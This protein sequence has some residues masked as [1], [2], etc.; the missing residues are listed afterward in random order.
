[1]IQVDYRRIVLLA[2][3][4]VVFL[5]SSLQA[6]NKYYYDDELIH[7]SYELRFEGL[8]KVAVEQTAGLLK[9][10]WRD[11][12][13]LRYDAGYI[14]Y[15]ELIRSNRNIS[16]SIK[17]WKNGTP[18]YYRRWWQSLPESKGGAPNKQTVITYG[19]TKKILDLKL[20][21]VTNALEIKWR[22]LELAVDFKEKSP[23][24]LGVGDKVH[25]PSSGWK[26]KIY[27]NFRVST[28]GVL[29]N[30]LLFIRRVDLSIGGVHTIRGVDLVAIL[31]NVQYAI[32]QH[33]LFFGLQIRLLQW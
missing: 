27:P 8:Y 3:L 33:E 15:V 12:E 25:K 17:E 16:D 7:G 29:K 5:S 6:Q 23:I 26:I 24:T 20:F 30:P 1:M 4:V 19:K 11:Q 10:R 9:V 28:R 32:Q 14:S 13:E 21:Y 22:G 2:F 31:L 18:W